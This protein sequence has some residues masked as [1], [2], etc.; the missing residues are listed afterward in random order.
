MEGNGFVPADAV[1]RAGRR[2]VETSVGKVLMGG[3]PY[4][5]FVQIR[6]SLLDL[7]S[8]VKERGEEHLESS[9][10]LATPEASKALDTIERT[11]VAAVISPRLY[12][13]PAD[14][15]TPI[16]FPI[17][18]RLAMFAAAMDLCGFTKGAAEEV[19]P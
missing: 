5:L 11:L 6:G 12:A 9:D 17:A 10:F 2:E 18:D 3:L 7:Q 4:A 19:R 13:N 1:K 15:P 8:L 14:G 16:D